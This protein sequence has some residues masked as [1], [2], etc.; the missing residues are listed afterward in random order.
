[1]LL[2]DGRDSREEEPRVSSLR[3]KKEEGKE[4]G[5]S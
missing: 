2:R 3:G 4:E 5:K 1:M